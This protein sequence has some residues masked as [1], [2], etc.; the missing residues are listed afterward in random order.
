MFSKILVAYDSSDL[1][2]KAL[3]KAIQFAKLDDKTKVH[4]VHVCNPPTYSYR[5]PQSEMQLEGMLRH[6]HELLEETDEKLAQI[7]PERT[8]KLVL[9]GQPSVMIL[10]YAQNHQCDLII[11]GSRGLSGVK[12]F[13]LGSVSHH[14]VQSSP[15]PVLIEK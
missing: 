1:G 14:V 4:V 12:E 10:E 9:K 6:A 5:Y 3:D 2:E 13:F 7:Q 15:V 8:E 11:M